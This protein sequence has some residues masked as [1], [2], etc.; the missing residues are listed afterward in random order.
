MHRFQIATFGAVAI[1]FAVDG[2]GGIFT[3]SPAPTAQGVGWLLLSIVDILWVLYFTSEEDS[4]ALH[5]FNSLGTGGLTPPGRRSRRTRSTVMAGGGGSVG[6]GNGGGGNGYSSPYNQGGYDPKLAPAPMSGPVMSG[7][8]SF[9]GVGGPGSFGGPGSAADTRSMRSMNRPISDVSNPVMHSPQMGGGELNAG[10][11]SPLMGSGNA[12][13]GAGGGPS[14][15]NLSGGGPDA[16]TVISE[17]GQAYT[18]KALYACKQS[19]SL[20]I[21]FDMLTSIRHR[22]IGRPQRD[23]LYQGRDYGNSGQTGQMVAS[24]ES[25]WTYWK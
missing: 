13:V 23:L 21:I 19:V 1:V 7:P 16:S 22:I 5:L 24:K 8:G 6:G 9:G 2:A 14:L 25:R 10:P 15:T 4:L 17:P 12:G 11:S 18:A 20:L 3:A